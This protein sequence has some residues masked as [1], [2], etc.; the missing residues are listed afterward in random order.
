MAQPRSNRTSGPG[1]DRPHPSRPVLERA[2][3]LAGLPAEG[4]LIRQGLNAVWRLERVPVIVRIARNAQDMD[5]ALKELRV[6]RWL[7][8]I[9]IP[10]VTPA[11]RTPVRPVLVHGRP[12][13]FWAL[14]DAPGPAPS[15]DDL[16]RLLKALHAVTSAPA[17]GLPSFD[18]VTRAR[19]WLAAATWV[20]DDDR[21]FLR[22]AC[23]QV[24]QHLDRLRLTP[25][26]VLHGDALVSNLAR[27]TRGPLLLDFE[28][29]S[30]GPREWDLVPTAVEAARFG[31]S[32]DS[33]LEFA[34]SY[35]TDIR[36]QPGYPALRRA[37]ELVQVTWRALSAG[38]STACRTEALHRIRSLRDGD[39]SR[40]WT[41][42]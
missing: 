9:G 17:G 5:A 22:N 37:R 35:G 14:A 39:L 3:A 34:R 32:E 31:R 20:S 15:P 11:P 7:D 42:L 33:Y 2:C 4:T 27:G 38:T 21:A 24:Q 19:H 10:A 23:E 18:P 41:A 13:T 1:R 29:A 36:E 25:P 40:Q 6:A 28:T 12:V 16:A 26:V 8:G 30:A